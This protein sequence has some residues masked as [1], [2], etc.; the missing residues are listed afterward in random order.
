MATLRE[1]LAS[2]HLQG[3]FG[4]KPIPQTVPYACGCCAVA[5]AL[6]YLG[7]HAYE[8]MMVEALQPKAPIGIELGDAL[9]YLSSRGFKATAWS[10]YPT[11]HI[12]GRVRSGKVTIIEW[13]DR[14]DHWVIV[15]GIEPVER[16]FVIADPSRSAPPFVGIPFDLFS[17]AWA[18]GPR[19][20]LLVDRFNK[21][22]SAA[23]A[24]KRLIFRVVD[25]EQHLRKHG[26]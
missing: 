17:E 20:V 1:I 11:E 15:A 7:E 23:V 21:D 26:R 3:L 16:V 24:K 4:L 19:R 8:Q 5:T 25:Y 2:K 22:E 18:A 6:K 9:K 13:A 12:L 14:P 10:K